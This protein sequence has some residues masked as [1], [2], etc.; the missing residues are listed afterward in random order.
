M[1]YPESDTEVQMRVRAF[2]QELQRLGWIEGSK[3]QFDELWTT[4]NM[5]LVRANAAS[6]L[7]LKPDVIVAVG[8]RVIPILKQ[9]TRE[10]RSLSP[11]QLIQ[12]VCGFG[13]ELSASRR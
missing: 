6:L 3:V 13:G 2:K 4:D 7:I 5:D 10:F 12:L 8:N 11:E 9:M 1:P